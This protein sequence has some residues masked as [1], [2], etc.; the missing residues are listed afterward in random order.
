MSH[1]TPWSMHGNAVIAFSTRK[2]RKCLIWKYSMEFSIAIVNGP[3]TGWWLT[4]GH[5]AGTAGQ[6]QTC[7]RG[8]RSSGSIQGQGC[9]AGRWS[10]AV[11]SHAASSFRRRAASTRRRRLPTAA[12]TNSPGWR[13]SS[14]AGRGCESSSWRNEI[15]SCV[16]CFRTVQLGPFLVQKNN[17]NK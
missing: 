11:A 17:A 3:P 6:G 16:G 14:S 9:Y 5:R 2:F 1:V 15:W 13:S 7:C 4:S 10:R 8:S 12:T